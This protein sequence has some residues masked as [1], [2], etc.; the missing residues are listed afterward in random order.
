MNL[1]FQRSFKIQIDN[2][3][4]ECFDKGTA[5]KS[6]L[7]HIDCRQEGVQMLRNR[8]ICTPVHVDSKGNLA[9][10]FT[11]ILPA[12]DFERL[13]STIMYEMADE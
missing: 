10:L 2:A 6:K 3:G 7:K 13:R 8:D 5:F 1:D 11:K 4:A 9:D 12:Q